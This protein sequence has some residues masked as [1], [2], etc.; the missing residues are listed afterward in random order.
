MRTR[1]QQD[2]LDSGGTLRVS[3]WTLEPQSETGPHTHPVDYVVIPT[4]GGAL[5]IEQDA[6]EAIFDMSAG[7]PYTRPAGTS[8]NLINIGDTVVI[9]IEVERVS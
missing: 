1:A 6:G 7:E 3:R 9:F 8:H 2:I 5:K 4:S